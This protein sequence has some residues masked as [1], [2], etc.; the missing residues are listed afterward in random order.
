MIFDLHISWIKID[1][2]VSLKSIWKCYGY[3]KVIKNNRSK[4][5]TKVNI[6]GHFGLMLKKKEFVKENGWFKI[7]IYGQI[8]LSRSHCDWTNHVDLGD[9]WLIS[10]IKIDLHVSLIKLD[11]HVSWL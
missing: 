4:K 3:L 2:H 7:I 8:C 1:L 10:W 9:I 11:L 5:T 6:F